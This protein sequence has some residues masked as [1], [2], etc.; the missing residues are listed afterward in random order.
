MLVSN[1][2][3]GSANS[4]YDDAYPVSWDTRYQLQITNLEDTAVGYTVTCDF[5][6]DD[7]WPVD[8]RKRKAYVSERIGWFSSYRH[9]GETV[10]AEAEYGLGA[11]ETGFVELASKVQDGSR[12]CGVIR[13]DTAPDRTAT[14]R[15]MLRPFAVGVLLHARRSDYHVGRR[16]RIM[17][18][19]PSGTGSR[20]MAHFIDADRYSSESVQLASGKA[21]N[22]LESPGLMRNFDDRILTPEWLS[23]TLE[24]RQRHGALLLPEDERPLALLDLLDAVDSEDEHVDTVNEALS[25]LGSR[26]RINRPER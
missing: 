13:L 11:G 14:G 26:V 19:H 17:E 4:Y 23:E 21:E 24:V 3:F 7:G 15:L 12:L 9:H 2:E 22:T 5:A 8:R 25:R 6:P 20:E 1:F 16:R 18:R 10:R